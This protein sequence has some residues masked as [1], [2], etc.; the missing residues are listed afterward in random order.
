MFHDVLHHHIQSDLV[1]RSIFNVSVSTSIVDIT[2]LLNCSSQGIQFVRFLG[3]RILHSASIR[4]IHLS[5]GLIAQSL[6]IKP[7][8]YETQGMDLLED[9]PPF[10]FVSDDIYT[11]E[12]A[13]LQGLQMEM[14]TILNS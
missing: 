5:E 4:L 12:I 13:E 14:N 1:S 11:P 2:Q 8:L 10:F 3:S 9:T 7:V 6:K